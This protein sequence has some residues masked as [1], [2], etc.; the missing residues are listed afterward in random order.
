M[1]L[2]ARTPTGPVH[3]GKGNITAGGDGTTSSDCT[4]EASEGSFLLEQSETVSIQTG[5]TVM[6]RGNLKTLKGD[7]L[8]E[9][10]MTE[11]SDRKLCVRERN[12]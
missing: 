1:C 8:S 12:D 7:S 4:H 9:K 11:R 10:V 3:C 5:N 2:N 6:D